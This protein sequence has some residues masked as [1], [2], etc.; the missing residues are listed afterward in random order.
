MCGPEV[1]G[2]EGRHQCEIT[3]VAERGQTQSSQQHSEAVR[4][5]KKAKTRENRSGT[6]TQTRGFATQA[7]RYRSPAESACSVEKA[8][9]AKSGPRRYERRCAGHL[10]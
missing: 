5:P 1:I 9:N 10:L 7:V 3:S 8:H 6:H 4:C 2:C